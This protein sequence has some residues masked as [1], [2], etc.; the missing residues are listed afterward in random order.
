MK[1]YEH[2][3]C[4]SGARYIAGIDEAGRGPIAGPVVAAA[5]ILPPD[6]F[7][8]RVDDSKKVA[9]QHRSQLAAA[10]KKE[11]VAW[12]I[13]SVNPPCLDRI[14]ILNAT[15][16]AMRIAVLHL[17]P[18]ADFL[19]IDAVKL[20]DINIR[21]RSIIKGDSLSVSIACASILAKV[22][23]DNK[24]E[25]YEDIY[26]GYGFARHKGYA[27]REHLEAIAKIGICPIH[28]ASFEP[29]KSILSGGNYGE[30]PGLFDQDYVEYK[31]SG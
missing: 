17:T 6:F 7:L 10:I 18:P 11:A 15:R 19:L 21:Q 8:P 3:A 4:R 2:D 12:S 1:G 26:P 25:A 16:E 27:T 29:V 30:Q 5:V 28:R 22:E 24:M 9:A 31:H 13:V 14:N 20:S 23:R